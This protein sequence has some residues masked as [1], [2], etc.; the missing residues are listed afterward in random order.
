VTNYAQSAVLFNWTYF[1]LS[2]IKILDLFRCM[3]V[4]ACAY[5][6]KCLSWTVH[7][8][9]HEDSSNRSGLVILS[10]LRY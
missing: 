3:L 10:T 9:E 1:Q 4:A 2:A 7:I 8:F 5:V 6:L